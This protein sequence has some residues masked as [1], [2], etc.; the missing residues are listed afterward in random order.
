V[1]GSLEEIARVRPTGPEA[2]YLVPRSPDPGRFYR[3][4]AIPEP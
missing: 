2:E 1:D 3:I 4:E